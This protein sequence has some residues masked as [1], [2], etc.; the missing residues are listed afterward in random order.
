MYLSILVYLIL[1]IFLGP[2][3]QFNLCCLNFTTIFG[4]SNATFTFIQKYGDCRYFC[5]I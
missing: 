5:Q 1:C 2:Y 4:S 3:L